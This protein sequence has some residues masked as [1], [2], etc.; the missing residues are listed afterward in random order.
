MKQERIF[1]QTYFRFTAQKTRLNLRFKIYFPSAIAGRFSVLFRH[2]LHY[3]NPLSADIWDN[4]PLLPSVG[5]AP[6]TVL[7]LGIFQA[8]YSVK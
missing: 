4:C 8:F 5:E 6:L 2:N 1:L 7:T 3:R